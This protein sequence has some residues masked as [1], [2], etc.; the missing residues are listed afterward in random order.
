[1]Q[2]KIKRKTEKNIHKKGD[3]RLDL[4]CMFPGNG[5]RKRIIVSKFIWICKRTNPP[6]YSR[7]PSSLEW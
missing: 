7:D 2:K 3:T 1:M 4:D 6:S 5:A